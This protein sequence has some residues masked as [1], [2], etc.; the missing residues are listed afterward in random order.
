[1]NWTEVLEQRKALLVGGVAAIC[2]AALIVTARRFNI[3]LDVYWHI[4]TGIDWLYH[5]L[6]PWRDHYSFTYYQEAIKSQPYLFQA[7]VGWLATEF[8]AETG[9]EIL[10][11]VCWVAVLGLVFL[12]L[13]TLKSPVVVYLIVVP[14][15]T[16]LLQQRPV[17]R[18]ELISYSLIVVAVMLYYRARLQ[19]SAATMLPIVLLVWF[20]NNYHS[21]VFSYVIFFG[22][23]LDTAVRYL[24]EHADAGLWLR[25]MGWGFG[26]IAVWALKPGFQIPFLGLIMPGSESFSPEWKDLILEYVSLKTKLATASWVFDWGV[27]AMGAITAVTVAMA[28]LRKYPGVIVVCG[29]LIYS[30]IEMSRLVTPNGI[31]ALC[32]F[33]WVVG[34]AGSVRLVQRLPRWSVAVAGAAALGIVALSM[35]SIV[36]FAQ[37]NMILNRTFT[38][39]FPKDVT[40]YMIENGIAGRIF[41]QYEHG[42]YLIYRLAPDS[43]VYIDGRTNILYPVEHAKRSL[44]ARGVPGVLAEEIEKYAIDLALLN[45]SKH[46]F[47][48]VQDTNLLQLDFVGF[49]H[50]LFR[51]DNARFPLLGRLLARP[52]CWSADDIPE[53]L[54]ERER[55]LTSLPERS[56]AIDFSG[57]LVDYAAAPDGRVFL[58]GAGNLEE[59]SDYMLRFAGYQALA[60][61][62]NDRAWEYFARLRE[63]EFADYL[64]VAMSRVAAND[65]RNAEQALDTLTRT[66]WGAVKQFELEILYRLLRTIRR[67]AGLELF[68]E[69]Y[70]EGL[71]RQFTESAGSGPSLDVRAFCLA[72]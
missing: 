36:W 69:S 7:L 9:L 16:L 38:T 53:L 55:A 42:G 3:T 50:S 10:R 27:Y 62:A 58:E 45:N 37:Q 32:L 5:G 47:T 17:A 71:A 67:N 61:G 46:N 54:V 20:W 34:E 6:S 68:D 39:G 65:W 43:R 22:L 57:L 70:L 8:G 21:A 33:A 23:F 25:W 4:Q 1:M 64:A 26:L 12:F 52:A 24:R 13:R 30:S 51:K 18:P 19:M 56:P 2:L 72:R 59:W 63:T 48:L 31:A 66:R 49:E 28:A 29:V 60:N 14:M 41:N 35:Y 40:D 15:L 11:G 44:E